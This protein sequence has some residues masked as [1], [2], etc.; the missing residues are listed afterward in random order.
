MTYAFHDNEQMLWDGLRAAGMLRRARATID[1][2]TVEFDVE[3]TRPDIPVLDG[4]TLSTQWTAEYVHDDAPGITRGTEVWI[5][6]PGY[7]GSGRAFTVR[8]Y[9][10]VE[11][12]GS[13]YFR[14]MLLTEEPCED[15]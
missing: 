2:C 6:E 3:L 4:A 13:G 11:D 7:E 9:P 14:T 5:E 8:D 12:R 10:G 1:D 15:D